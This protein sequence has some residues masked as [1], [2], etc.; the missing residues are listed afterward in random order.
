MKALIYSTKEFEKASLQN[1]N[2]Q[3]I[4]KNV[5]ISNGKGEALKIP[6]AHGEGR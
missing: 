4:C 6:I 5:Y 2:Q 1:A 3:F